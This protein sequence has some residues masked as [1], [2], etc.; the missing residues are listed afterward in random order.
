VD[1]PIL[2]RLHPLVFRSDRDELT[3]GFPEDT[4]EA[5]QV[6][7]VILA[8]QADPGNLDREIFL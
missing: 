2:L 4:H 3:V 5:L 7:E 6:E 1:A 8:A